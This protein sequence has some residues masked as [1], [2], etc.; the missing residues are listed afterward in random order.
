MILIA[1][2]ERGVKGRFTGSLIM[3][4]KAVIKAEVLIVLFKAELII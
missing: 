3:R 4:I 1:L 2:A